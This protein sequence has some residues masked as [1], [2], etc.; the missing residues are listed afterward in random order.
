MLLLGL[1]AEPGLGLRGAWK[2]GLAS[3]LPLSV[4]PKRG[5]SALWAAKRCTAGLPASLRKAGPEPINNP[6]LF[7]AEAWRLCSAFALY[8]RLDWQAGGSGDRGAAH[9]P[10]I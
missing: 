6:A 3:P 4:C 9:R 10:R 8:H 5:L 2:S 7:P 1:K